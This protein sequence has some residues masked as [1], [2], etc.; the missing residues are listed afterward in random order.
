MEGIEEDLLYLILHRLIE[1][2]DVC[3]WLWRNEQGSPT[4]VAPLMMVLQD[5]RKAF[6]RTKRETI[7]LF[8]DT[9][10]NCPRVLIMGEGTVSPIY[11]LLEGILLTF[12]E[13]FG[14]EVGM[15]FA[16]IM[17]GRKVRGKCDGIFSRKIQCIAELGNHRLQAA[18]GEE[19]SCHATDF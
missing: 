12:L 19:F 9:Q 17:A 16:K 7:F 13:E 11:L 14:L 8:P 18:Y 4:F 5:W 15:T 2:T 10:G 6:P 3:P 1:W